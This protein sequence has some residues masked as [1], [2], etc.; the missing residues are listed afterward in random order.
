M[1]LINDALKRAKRVRQETAEPT[2][3]NLPFRP[4]DLDPRPARRGLGLLLPISLAAV[5]LL[6]LLLLWELSK[7][8]SAKP[9]QPQESLAVAARTP[10]SSDA[11]LATAEP[12][13]TPSSVPSA[14]KSP[15]PSSLVSR[16]ASETAAAGAVNS[17]SVASVAP[18]SSGTA[19]ASVDQDTVETNRTA[20][21]EPSPAVPAPLKLQGIVFD[22]KR[23]S[24]M[25]NGHVVFVGD[26]IRDVRVM[27]IQ[28][29]NV[30]LVGASRTNL[31]SL[32]P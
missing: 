13:V 9:G 30:L 29:D 19:S 27:A 31:L 28:Q 14:F 24:A 5:A 23:P 22:R 25:I 6:G 18:A 26:R 12:P 21:T 1:S 32:E 20:M 4:V 7:R 2:S 3:P 15:T 16:N 8:D 11:A 17:T 10:P